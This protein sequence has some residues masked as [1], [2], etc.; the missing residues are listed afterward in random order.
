MSS[1]SPTR[2]AVAPCPS[3]AQVGDGRDPDVQPSGRERP[4]V[5]ADDNGRADILLPQD[6]ERRGLDG[7]LVMDEFGSGHQPIRIRAGGD[8]AT[9]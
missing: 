1:E 7:G 2:R 4:V 5:T 3:S 8:A 9:R 6:L